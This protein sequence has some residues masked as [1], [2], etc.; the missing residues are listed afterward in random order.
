MQA[1]VSKDINKFNHNQQ[2]DSERHTLHHNHESN[3]DEG[4]DEVDFFEAME[5]DGVCLFA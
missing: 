1:D 2:K 3:T 4:N 5:Q